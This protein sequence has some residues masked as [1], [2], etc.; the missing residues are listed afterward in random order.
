VINCDAQAIH[1]PKE[2]ELE[3]IAYR[4]TQKSTADGVFHGAVLMLDGFLSPRTKPAVTNAADYHT[5]HK[6]IFALNHVQAA[7]D[8]DFRF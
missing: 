3:S 6:K 2:E 7:C 8:D 1:L 4:W 5:G